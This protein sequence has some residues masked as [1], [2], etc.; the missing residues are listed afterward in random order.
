MVQ[1]M[2]IIPERHHKLRSR[3]TVMYISCRNAHKRLLSFAN[4]TILPIVAAF[5]FAAIF[6]SYLLEFLDRISRKRLSFPFFWYFWKKFARSGSRKGKK[7][8]SLLL[9]LKANLSPPV[10]YF[11]FTIVW[12][13]QHVWKN[14]TLNTIAI[15]RCYRYNNTV[16]VFPASQKYYE[17]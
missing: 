13:I 12:L 3:E 8:S 17:Y 1:S 7:G 10:W 2:Q 4:A 16:L 11:Q 5:A 9:T 6:P 15:I 14:V